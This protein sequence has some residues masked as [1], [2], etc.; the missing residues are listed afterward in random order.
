M[1]TLPC[2]TQKRISHTRDRQT[3]FVS[4]L[5]LGGRVSAAEVE[6]AKLDS[7]EERANLIGHSLMREFKY[8]FFSPLMLV[9]RP[10][11]KTFPL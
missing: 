11:A 5:I 8:G 4:T 2:G 6:L 9:P 10:S 1:L 7:A 3:H